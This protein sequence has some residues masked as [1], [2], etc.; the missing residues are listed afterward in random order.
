MLRKLSVALAVIAFG[1]LAASAADTPYRDGSGRFSVTVP[2][3]WSAQAVGDSQIA[4]LIGAPDADDFS[5]LCIV[6]VRDVPELRSLTQA[7]IDEVFGKEM[8][9]AFWEAAF[10][11]TNAK[12]VTVEDNGTRAQNGHQA[13]YAVGSATVTLPTGA[14]LRAKTKL[15]MQV[16]PGSFH[17]VNCRAKAETFA[18]YEAQFE[19]VFAS[20]IPLGSGYIASLPQGGPVTLNQARPN[21]RA[22]LNA[23]RVMISDQLRLS[24]YPRRR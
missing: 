23:A 15:Q 21:A 24:Q 1:S 9:R 12:D 16:I 3:G 14:V 6:M 20:H 7:Q 10:Q 2:D 5:G 11:A 18:G 8:T 4:L 19:K 13:Y 17:A 22:T